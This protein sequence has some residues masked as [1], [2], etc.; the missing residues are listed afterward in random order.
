MGIRYVDNLDGTLR[1]R[2]SALA[3]KEKPDPF[4]EA[5]IQS[6]SAK[7]DVAND[8]KQDIRI[9]IRDA[10]SSGKRML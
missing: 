3:I 9:A 2:L 7:Y 1:Q 10:R 8:I 5:V 4:E 6:L